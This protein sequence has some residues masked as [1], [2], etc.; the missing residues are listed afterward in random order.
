MTGKELISYILDNNLENQRLFEIK[1][2]IVGFA[3]IEEFAKMIN[4]G[5]EAV[6][7]M[8]HLRMIDAIEICGTSYVPYF[9]YKHMFNRNS[10]EKDI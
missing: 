6:M 1:D 3:T 4:T 7:A 10:D 9:K 2:H 8:I 5:T